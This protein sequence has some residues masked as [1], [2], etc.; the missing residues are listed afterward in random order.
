M[1]RELFAIAGAAAAAAREQI[2]YAVETPLRI[3]A[4]GR[5][6][7][8]SCGDLARLD[9]SAGAG[10]ERLPDT[11]LRRRRHRSRVRLGPPTRDQRRDNIISAQRAEPEQWAA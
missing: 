3:V 9:E 10:V 5:P 7:E 11:A 1:D 8:H 4:R 2:L 6:R